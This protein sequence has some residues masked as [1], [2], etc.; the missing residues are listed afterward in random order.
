MN[1]SAK[2]R[3]FSMAAAMVLPAIA[4][5]QSAAVTPP[6]EATAPTPPPTQEPPAPGTAAA[7]SVP[8]RPG[9][10]ATTQERPTTRAVRAREA[11]PEEPIA[12]AVALPAWSPSTSAMTYYTQTAPYYR[13]SVPMDKEMQELVKKESELA[14]KTQELVANL[15]GAAADK[16]AEIRTQLVSTVE[17]HFAVRQEQ[18]ELQLK[19]IEEEVKKLREAIEKRTTSKKEIIERRIAELTGEDTIGF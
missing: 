17:A 3:V 12:P 13:Y 9:V 19:R 4:F 16:K 8:R 7:P 14:K 1:W 6:A 11:R 2:V 18:R 10:V 5:G 15:K